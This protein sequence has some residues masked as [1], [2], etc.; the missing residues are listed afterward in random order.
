MDCAELS[1]IFNEEV[2]WFPIQE[3]PVWTQRTFCKHKNKGEV[4]RF[5]A[6]LFLN[7]MEP[8]KAAYWTTADRLLG[9]GGYDSDRIRDLTNIVDCLNGKRGPN[10][11]EEY[12]RRLNMV[13]YYDLT[14][15][16]T[17]RGSN[18]A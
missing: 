6:F 14:S 5:F 3:W 1:Y 7:G 17:L 4:W 11:E 9:H 10:K 16:T 18:N 13:S 15:K 12:R 2:D 8:E